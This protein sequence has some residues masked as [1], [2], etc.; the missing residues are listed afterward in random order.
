MTHP[1]WPLFDLRIR[2]PRLVLR[3]VDEQAATELMVLADRG[4][5]E[6][7]TM[8][9]VVPWTTTPLPQRHWEGMQYYWGRWAT[10]SAEEWHL[11]FAS[12]AVDPSSGGGAPTL[13][14][15]IELGARGFPTARVVD[16][17]SWIGRDFHGAGF[18]TEQRAAMLRFAFDALGA[19]RA[20][21]AAWEDNT[22]SR[23]VSEKLGYR[24][25]GDHVASSEG[26]SRRG[27]DFAFDVEDW[28]REAAVNPLHVPVEV[29]GLAAALPQFGL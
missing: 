21:S 10:W 3:P 24:D 27:V 8:P 1:T 26:R 22:A 15:M 11:P 13:V 23:R 17:G 14:G 18:G 29:D 6:P 16:T 19:T 9:F 4:V 12:Y 7:G 5:H 2:T 20:V 28:R 25:N